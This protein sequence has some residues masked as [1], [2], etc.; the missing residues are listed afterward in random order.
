[1]TPSNCRFATDAFRA[2]QPDVEPT[3]HARL[4][5]SSKTRSV[6]SSKSL[7]R[8][9][10]ADDRMNRDTT[11]RSARPLLSNRNGEACTV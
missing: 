10:A 3:L 8:I 4:N 9:V 1:M 11:C 5:K 2:T 7:G 6:Y